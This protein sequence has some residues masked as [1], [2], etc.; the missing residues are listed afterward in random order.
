MSQSPAGGSPQSGGA[1]PGPPTAEAIFGQILQQMQ[2]GMGQMAQDS[3]RR[4]ELLE[5]AIREQATVGRAS[6]E[7]QVKALEAMTKKSSVVDVKGVGKPETLK[8][9]HED[10]RKVW[11]TWSYKF[12]S[13]FS[14][15]FPAKG[16]ECL[17]WARNKGDETILESAITTYARTCPE[18]VDVDRQL[19]VALISL[20]AE[21]PYTVVFNAR[22]RCGLDAW[23]RLCHVYE[24]HNARS[25]MRLLRRILVQ[26]RATL[27]QLRAAIDK[28]EAD[29]AE[30]VQRGNRDLDDPQKVTILLSMVL[31]QLEDHLEMNI[32]RLD[33]YAK[34]RAEVISYTEQ[35]A[36]KIDDGGAA[37]MDLDTFKGNKGGKGKGGKGKEKY[38]SPDKDVVC[39]LCK[40]KGHRKSACWYAKEN[41]GTGKPP[42]RKDPK[43]GAKGEKGGKGKGGKGKGKAHSFEGEGEEEQEWPEG[44]GQDGEQAGDGDLGFLCVLGPSADS[45]P[46]L[47]PA[48]PGRRRT[49]PTASQ[50]RLGPSFWARCSS[51]V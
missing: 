48:A 16:Q 5:A 10:A 6:A 44:D 3:N 13:W 40:K 36:A 8:G 28:W 39:H 37:P 18:V 43:A 22:K 2:A 41:G 33:T 30:Y 14:S 49:R 21:M 45:A 42:E 4:F 15:Q 1:N 9:C 46:G 23:R 34:A 51:L 25:N 12:E 47:P 26:P 24:P 20:T 35:K 27:E 29:L 38:H 31:E 32:G 11:K 19:H 17:D 50:A 7:A